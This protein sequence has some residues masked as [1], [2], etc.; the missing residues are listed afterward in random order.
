M[1]LDDEVSLK[2]RSK[3]PVD[4]G[5]QED[6]EVLSEQ[7]EEPDSNWGVDEDWKKELVKDKAIDEE[8]L[9]RVLKEHNISEHDLE[10]TLKEDIQEVD[11]NILENAIDLLKLLEGDPPSLVAV[12]FLVVSGY[13]PSEL[14]FF[15]YKD[16]AGNVIFSKNLNNFKK[17]KI[18]PL[19]EE[20]MTQKNGINM[21]T[22]SE[23]LKKILGDNLVR[24]GNFQKE[25]FEENIEAEKYVLPS[26]LGDKG[27]NKESVDGENDWRTTRVLGLDVIQRINYATGDGEVEIPTVDE[28]GEVTGTQKIKESDLTL[29]LLENDK[30]GKVFNALARHFWK[31]LAMHGKVVIDKDG[32]KKIKVQGDLDVKLSIK[33][34][35]E[36]GIKVDI[37]KIKF[38]EPGDEVQG[39][40]NVDTSSGRDDPLG[41]PGEKKKFDGINTILEEVIVDGKTQWKVTLIVDHHS[42]TSKSDSSA[43]KQLYEGLF[44]LGL[45]EKVDPDF[46]KLIEFSALEDNGISPVE[47]EVVRKKYFV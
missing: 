29:N 31:E 26:E 40:V 45:I 47:M 10:V 25:E 30:E 2:Q 42:K 43:A 18:L 12:N 33:V 24:L 7:E 23:G 3:K 8:G 4:D 16:K 20:L 1:S 5:R 13:S 21:A 28:N 38:V 46:V 34:L 22:M 37:E 32:E 27:E 17:E 44:K 11:E 19:I 6:F 41:K 15:T 39:R 14:G 9:A 36:A 35:E